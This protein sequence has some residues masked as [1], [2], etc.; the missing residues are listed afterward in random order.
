MEKE[1][2]SYTFSRIKWGLLG[3]VIFSTVT[4]FLVEGDYEKE[5]YRLMNLQCR[6]QENI[7]TDSPSSCH[8]TTIGES[9]TT[10]GHT[11]YIEHDFGFII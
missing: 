5:H 1:L 8:E 6:V 3:G 9:K 2:R 4:F 11:D 7:K 10:I